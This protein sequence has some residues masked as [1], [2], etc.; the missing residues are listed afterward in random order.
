LNCGR[1]TPWKQGNILLR[2]Y[3]GRESPRGTARRE[4][5]IRRTGRDRPRECA[6]PGVKGKSIKKNIRP[7]HGKESSV[8]LVLRGG[9]KLKAGGGGVGKREGLSVLVG[10]KQFE[11]ASRRLSLKMLRRGG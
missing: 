1:K 7:G 4:G 6:V 8:S 3:S 11:N 2:K 5:E 9:K 10:R